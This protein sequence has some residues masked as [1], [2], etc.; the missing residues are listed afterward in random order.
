MERARVRE[1][2]PI[3]AVPELPDD[4]ALY[5]HCLANAGYFEATTF[6]SDDANRAQQ[7]VEN[8]ARDALR[9]SMPDLGEFLGSLDMKLTYGAFTRVDLQRITQLINKT[10]QFN[11]TTRRYSSEQVTEAALADELLTLQFRLVDRCGDN[12]LVSAMILRP[13]PGEPGVLDIDTWVMSCRVF[14][15]Q[16]EFEAM[17]IAVEAARARGCTALRATFE[18]SAKNG[19]V[20]DLYPRLGFLPVECSSV[21]DSAEQ[22]QIKL[23]DYVAQ[24][25]HIVR[26]SVATREAVAV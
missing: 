11:P 4:A 18:P 13:L 24:K 8:S 22:W 21:A 14:G 5:V 12:G 2:L 23:D 20:K 17:N 6:T 3:V 15:R 25:T 1:S 26:Q 9:A 16:L 10:N 19:V 7:Y